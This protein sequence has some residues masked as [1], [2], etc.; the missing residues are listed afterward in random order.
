[1]KPSVK[2]IKKP[3]IDTVRIVKGTA[4]NDHKRYS[5]WEHYEYDADGNMI[6]SKNSYG[7]EAW[8]EYD[9]GGNIIHAKSSVGYDLSKKHLNLYYQPLI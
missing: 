4:F 9:A 1:M 2:R 5:F 3:A 7:C 6:H 8:N